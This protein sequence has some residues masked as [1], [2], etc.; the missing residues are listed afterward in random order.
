MMH[1]AC[2]SGHVAGGTCGQHWDRCRRPESVWVPSCTATG[3]GNSSTIA[4][5]DDEIGKQHNEAGAE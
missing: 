3:A 5:Y 1:L 2:E 4:G